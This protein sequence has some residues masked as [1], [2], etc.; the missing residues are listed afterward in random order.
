MDKAITAFG[1]NENICP[2]DWLGNSLNIFLTSRAAEMMRRAKKTAHY[3]KIWKASPTPGSIQTA[4]A[5]SYS[6]PGVWSWPSETQSSLHQCDYPCQEVRQTE[7]LKKDSVFHSIVT[8]QFP[9]QS[10]REY[11]L[12]CADSHRGHLNLRLLLLSS[13]LQLWVRPASSL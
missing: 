2:A 13:E 12:T 9:S 10:V 7:N 1:S 3:C 4:S 6:A 11:R 8:T 5:G